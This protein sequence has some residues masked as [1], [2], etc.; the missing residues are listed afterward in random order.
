MEKPTIFFQS[1]DRK[2]KNKRLYNLSILQFIKMILKEILYYIIKKNMSFK[3]IGTIYH[4]DSLDEKTANQLNTLLE[5]KLEDVKPYSTIFE[6]W[7]TG[8]SVYVRVNIN[9]TETSK[10]VVELAKTFF[11]K[12]GLTVNENNGYIY[13]N[14]YLYDYPKYD[15]NDYGNV[16]WANEALAGVH[17]CVFITRKDTTIKGGEL[18]IYK[19][20]P[21]TFLR[22]FGLEGDPQKEIY[23]L[24]SGSVFVCSGDVLHQFMNCG[25]AGIYNFINVTLYDHK[26]YGYQNDN[27]D[28][29]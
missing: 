14:S 16:S 22:M 26:R 28:D 10:Q 29:D 13:Y 8:R 17:E 23:K 3:P 25:G 11:E 21:N 1:L 5:N 6:Y 27:D 19:E 12:A 15:K 20:N 2:N 4:V 24:E 18:E 7:K 9:K